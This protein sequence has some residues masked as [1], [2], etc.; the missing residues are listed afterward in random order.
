VARRY[1]IVPSSEAMGTS[2]K[3]QIAVSYLA[4][5]CTP[6]E[7]RVKFFEALTF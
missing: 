3:V 5:L 7:L 6:P 1:V 4:S 2:G